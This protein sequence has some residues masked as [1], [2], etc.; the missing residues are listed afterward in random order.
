MLAVWAAAAAKE[1]ERVFVTRASNGLFR[2]RMTVWPADMK[3]C[4]YGVMDGQ[5]GPRMSE[6]DLW[7][8]TEVKK[9][10]RTRRLPSRRRWNV[11]PMPR[12][13]A[14][15]SCSPR[16][17]LGR[18][19]PTIKVNGDAHQSHEKRF[20][21]RSQQELGDFNLFTG[22]FLCFTRPGPI[23]TRCVRS[24]LSHLISFIFQPK[25]VA[26]TFFFSSVQCKS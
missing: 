22:Y 13:G 18:Q 10:T 17:R 2:R 4:P 16:K 20:S 24:P 5:G 3:P 1:W 11:F 12:T 14:R 6:R 15:Q 7:T 9:E 26:C 8:G 21:H 25:P 23:T 19:R